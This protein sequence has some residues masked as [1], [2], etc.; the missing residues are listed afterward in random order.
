MNRWCIL[1][2]CFL[3]YSRML[4][5]QNVLLTAVHVTRKQ[6]NEMKV[7]QNKEGRITCRSVKMHLII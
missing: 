4:C 3:F 5:C 1:M 6:N 2:F 7:L